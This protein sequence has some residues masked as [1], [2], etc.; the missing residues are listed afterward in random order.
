[1][2]RMGRK[3]SGK[4]QHGVAT[5]ALAAL[6]AVG[7]EYRTVTYER[8]KRST[9][10]FGLEA[11]R[12]TGVAP[13]LVLKTLLV[14][15]G[16]NLAVCV[17]PVDHMLN[18]NAAAHALGLKKVAL[19]EPQIAERV[20]G[21]VVGGISPLGQKR[22]LP[23]VIDASVQEAEAVLVSGGRRGLSVNLA[24]RDLAAATG[25]VFAAITD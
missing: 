15:E 9:E 13:S 23:T 22:R 25:A 3:S 16:K 7:V 6:D 17:L 24:P 2:R 5:P 1:M 20:T 11:A 21:Y 12:L 4:T 19:V 14:G 8:S 18:L 10:G